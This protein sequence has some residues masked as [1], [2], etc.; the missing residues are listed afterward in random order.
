VVSF[1]R[2]IREAHSTDR[3][4]SLA[5]MIHKV[6]LLPTC[7]HQQ[8]PFAYK[9]Y[10]NAD[11]DGWQQSNAFKKAFSNAVDIEFLGVWQVFPDTQ[12]FDRNTAVLTF[13]SVSFFFFFL[14]RD[15]VNSV[16]L[17]PRRLPFTTSNKVVKTF[18][19][20]VALD[21][22]RAKF[23]ANLWNRPN[24]KEQLLSVTDVQ[25]QKEA[26]VNPKPK[27]STNHNGK[28]SLRALENKYSK[29]KNAATDIDEVS[30][31]PLT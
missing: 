25:L 26:A 7:N 13:F 4:D 2:T 28:Q 12:A 10:T 27:K 22:R 6:G 8:V 15:T 19:H 24:P 1:P 30:H 17:I 3:S 23:K 14:H 21:E 29:D 11:D 20:A 16:G 18:R 5:G 31:I 9:M